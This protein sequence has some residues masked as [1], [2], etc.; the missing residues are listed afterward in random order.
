MTG[1]GRRPTAVDIVIVNWNTG[2]YLRECLHS[3]ARTDRSELSVGLVVVVDNAS[4]DDSARALDVPGL[5]LRVIRNGRNRG[6][7]AACNQG[8]LLCD[9]DYLLFLNPDTRLY[10]DTLRAAGAFLRTEAARRVGICGA[11]IVD[12]EGRTAIS[13]SRFPTLRV[14]LGGMT[15]LYRGFPGLFPPHHLRADDIPSDRSVDQ[16]IGAFYLVRRPLFVEL[17]GFDERYFLYFEEV[18]FALRAS[19]FGWASY[20]LADAR[21]YHAEHVSSDKTGGRGLGHLL[22]SRTLYA[23]RYWPRRDARVLVALTLL[24]E[25]PGRL[26][27]GGLRRSRSEIKDTAV[28]YREFVRW[29]LRSNRRMLT[30]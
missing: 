1:A 29:L 11:R 22:C 9:A 3:I 18:D 6:F 20:F 28:A 2:D 8:A 12:A 7:A 14:V 25:L 27:R 19:R 24:V 26:A 10:P 21:V 5:R 30:V 16:V 17:G 15:G 13:C 23:F 4:S